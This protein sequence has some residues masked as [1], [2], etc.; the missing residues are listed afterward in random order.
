[1]SDRNTFRPIKL[2][3][4]DNIE[5]N[6]SSD[7]TCLSGL[8][9]DILEDFS[10]DI[11]N[12]NVK[13]EILMRVVNYLEHYKVNKRNDINK[14]FPIEKDLI[15]MVEDWDYQFISNFDDESLLQ[16]IIAAE[17]MRINPLHDLACAKVADIMRKIL[18]ENGDDG[19][20]I[21]AQ[22]FGIDQNLD[23]EE[24]KKIEEEELSGIN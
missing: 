7:A 13:S 4:S 2:I 5:F 14:P 19:P 10:D 18:R 24:M 1:M 16:I 8:L 3:S 21:I 22:R 23:D 12:L 11:Y 17:Y 6:T 20:L 9:T 15:D